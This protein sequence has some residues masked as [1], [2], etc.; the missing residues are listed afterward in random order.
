MFDLGIHSHAV[1]KFLKESDNQ[2]RSYGSLHGLSAFL[3]LEVE[4]L[5]STHPKLRKMAKIAENRLRSKEDFIPVSQSFLKIL[6]EHHTVH[7]SSL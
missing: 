5:L 3:R 6:H 4:Y 2:H 7:F 1:Y